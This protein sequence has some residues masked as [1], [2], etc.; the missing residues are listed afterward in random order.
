MAENSCKLNI[1]GLLIRFT[2]IPLKAER[3][4]L[5]FLVRE[6]YE[7]EEADHTIHV[8]AEDEMHIP[9]GRPIFRNDMIRCFEDGDTVRTGRIRIRGEI[10]YAVSTD[11]RGEHRTELAL[12]RYTLDWDDWLRRV[13]LYCSLPHIMLDNGRLMLHASY[14]LTDKGGIVFCAPSGKGKSTQADLWQRHRGAEVI[15]GDRA[16]LRPTEEDGVL[17]YSMPFAGTSG[18]CKNRDSSLRAA[19]ELGR[20]VLAQG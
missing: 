11:V 18:I 17:V 10:P 8:T 7:S 13:L 15:N 4:T 3:F 16:I 20:R 12:E 5:P 9:E 2:G 1:G 14:A 19:G 6:G